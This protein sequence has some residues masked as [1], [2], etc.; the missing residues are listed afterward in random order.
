MKK[1]I[2]ILA[3][4]LCL[5]FAFSACSA[6][7][8]FQVEQNTNPLITERAFRQA[9]LNFVSNLLRDKKMNAAILQ[10]RKQKQDP[11][12]VPILFIEE[13]SEKDS[14][15]FQPQLESF[16]ETFQYELNACGKFIVKR[17]KEIPSGTSF[18][19]DFIFR[20]SVNPLY[21]K[22]GRT[23]IWQLIFSFQIVESVNHKIIWTCKK[24]F[25]MLKKQA[26]FGN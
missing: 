2:K 11:H 18:A 9:A 8:P 3:G 13:I 14:T 24:E 10:D 7:K 25:K 6:P 26:I 20:G 21:K 23:E 1:S 17:R 12:A 4:L 19:P 15:T 5:V 22:D 16:Y